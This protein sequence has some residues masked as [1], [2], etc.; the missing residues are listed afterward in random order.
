MHTA[1]SGYSATCDQAGPRNTPVTKMRVVSCILK[2][3]VVAKSPAR[4]KFGARESENQKAHLGRDL[5]HIN[6]PSASLSSHDGMG[7]TLGSRQRARPDRSAHRKLKHVGLT[8][9][10]G[11]SVKGSKGS[12]RHSRLLGHRSRWTIGTHIM[13]SVGLYQLCKTWLCST[14]LPTRPKHSRLSSPVTHVGDARKGAG[15]TGRDPRELPP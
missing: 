13:D 3:T 5:I 6:K 8:S 2:L 15:R 9:E 7:Q 14:P 4:W 12:S 11:G 10:D 1:H